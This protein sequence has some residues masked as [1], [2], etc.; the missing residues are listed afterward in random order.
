MLVIQTDILKYGAQEITLH[1]AVTKYPIL[2]NIIPTALI[3]VFSGTEICMMNFLTAQVA[4]M[5]EEVLKSQ[6]KVEEY[7]L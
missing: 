1:T 7:R 5:R 3:F 6:E 4:V 2:K